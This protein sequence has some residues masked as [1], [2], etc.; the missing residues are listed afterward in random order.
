M[1][2]C[3]NHFL[4]NFYLWMAS[5]LIMPMSR[6]KN[7][8]PDDLWK[9]GGLFCATALHPPSSLSW[10]GGLTVIMTYITQNYLLRFWTLSIVQNSKNWKTQCFGNWICF[11]SQVRGGVPKKELTSITGKPMSYNKGYISTWH[12]DE[13]NRVQQGRCLPPFTWGWK[14]IQFPKYCVF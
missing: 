11:C 10:G 13:S 4:H 5:G 7:R 3:Y 8:L 6:G 2:Y 14:Q 12:Q 9:Y 1:T